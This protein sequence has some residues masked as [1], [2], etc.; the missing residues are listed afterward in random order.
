MTRPG[1]AVTVPAALFDAGLD[2]VL[3]EAAATPAAR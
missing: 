3:A 1:A 2:A